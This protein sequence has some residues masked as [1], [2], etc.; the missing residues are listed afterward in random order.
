MKKIA[1]M[2][3]VIIWI[4][5]A[6]S[7][8]QNIPGSQ[9]NPT[10]TAAAPDPQDTPPSQESVS[11]A[12]TSPPE[13]GTDEQGSADD[14]DATIPHTLQ[15]SALF[16][17]AWDDRSIFAGGLIPEEQFIL[18]ELPGATMYRIDMQIP[19]DLLNIQGE[20]EVLYTNR[21][22]DTL[23][24]LYFRL[25][26]NIEGGV[27]EVSN[28]TVD[29]EK[30]DISI[31]SGDSA[32]VVYLK[33]TLQPGEDVLVQLDFSLEI[34]REMG[35]NYGLFGYFDE[36]LVL[37]LFYPVIPVYDE[38]GWYKDV[39]PHDGD[40]SYFDASFYM[41]RVT[42][43]EDLVLVASGV[44]VA[45]E[46]DGD[47]QVVTYAAGPARDFY[48][49]ASEHFVSISEPMGD[50]IVN[51]YTF[52]EHRE[53]QEIA[54]SVAL[55]AFSVYGERLGL[56]EYTEFDVI[57][58]PMLALGIEY[59]GAT[60]IT[61]DAFDP[62]AEI[63]GL[64]SQV[65]LESTVAHEVGHHYFYNA[66]GND[67]VRE[68][69]LD[70]AVVQYITA[71]YYLDSYGESAYQSLRSSWLGRWDRVDRVEDPIGLHNSDYEEGHYSPIVYGRGPLF[72]ETLAS[73]MGQETFDAFLREYYQSHT[74]RIGTTE[75]FKNLAEEFCACDLTG[76]FEEWVYPK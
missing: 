21:E 15:E 61:L 14:S 10:D 20:E 4:L 44:E 12:T 49:A 27:A 23:D 66:V 52:E 56:Y 47:R 62:Q 35:G 55:G 26:P 51:C 37:D 6:C 13:S 40:I 22:D 54:L 2:L 48:I 9:E 75:D 32:L 3:I 42:A 46:K 68:A 57:S 69:W 7:G 60:G 70:E 1:I 74:W 53:G 36:V 45:R 34:P 76:L 8:S 41:V 59:P 18:D 39:P 67:Q 33:D 50:T 30:V 72:I 25:F 73:E 63:A 71:L 24:E 16:G 65:I 17:L 11:D 5:A 31:E 64:P 38:N 19:D 29:G 43:V 58:T 28:V